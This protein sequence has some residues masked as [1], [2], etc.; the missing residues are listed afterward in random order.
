MVKF[1]MKNR[2]KKPTKPRE[3][4][5]KVGNYVT[6]EYLLECIEKFK[7]ENPDPTDR[8][9]M[10][11]AEH[12]DY[13]KSTMFLTAPAPSWTAYEASLQTYKIEL[14]AYKAWQAQNKKAIE[15]TKVVKKK[16]IAKRKLLRRMERLTKE[17]E[18]TKYK[19]AKP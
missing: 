18:E 3:V 1:K 2:P 15:K 13:T 12:C 4:N 16:Q 14:K 19:L 5:Y 17:L 6:V 10:V 11:E 8:E 7:A 9:M